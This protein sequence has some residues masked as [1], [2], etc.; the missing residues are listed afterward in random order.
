MTDRIT[1]DRD[2]IASGAL[3]EIAAK[4]GGLVRPLKPEEMEASLTATLAARPRPDPDCP[5][6]DDIWVFAYGSL[7][8]N[9]AFHFQE[10]RVGLVRGWHRRFCL[11]TVMGRGTPE[12]PGLVL[13]LDRGGACKGIAYRV[14]AAQAR[15]ELLVV[16]R[17]EMVTASYTPRWG[18]VDLGSRRVSAIL[19]TINRADAHYAPG[20]DE[21]TVAERMAT[22]E[23]ALGPAADYLFNTEEALRQEGILDVSLERV[24]SHARRLRNQK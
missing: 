19:F 18:K 20:L 17:R 9:P 13:G 11:S 10:R 23:G 21:R 7:I 3:Q 5:D 4:L 24:A 6:G 12:C 1:L 14:S 2:T 22:A 8:W 15:E 16:W